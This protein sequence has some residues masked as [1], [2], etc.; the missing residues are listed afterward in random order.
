MKKAE[1]SEEFKQSIVNLYRSG[2][3]S[4]EILN[5]YG[6]SSSVF[7]KWIK[8][9]SVV[10]ISETES[11]TMIEIKAMQKRLALLEEENMI[12]KKTISIFTRE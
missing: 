9:Y 3:P 2:K 11:M 6:M 10:Q 7:Y 8:K 1:Y 4:S 12:L 5:E